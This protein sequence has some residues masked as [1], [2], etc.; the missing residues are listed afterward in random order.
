MKV[1]HVFIPVNMLDAHWT[2]LVVSPA[3]KTIEYFDSM[4]RLSRQPTANVKAW[5]T[6]EFGPVFKEN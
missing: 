3:T 6:S 5:L 4:R 1:E 2:L